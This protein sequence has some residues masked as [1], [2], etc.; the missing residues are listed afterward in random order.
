MLELAR[1][2]VWSARWEIHEDPSHESR[3]DLP[4]ECR[5]SVRAYLIFQNFS[6]S[7]NRSSKIKAEEKAQ[8]DV[9][10][11]T[12]FRS[13][14]I[15]EPFRFESKGEWSNMTYHFVVPMSLL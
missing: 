12:P 14:P 6:V 2:K 11:S 10:V 4:R 1:Q 13:I 5:Y 7:L 9:N 15:D 3:V 8:R